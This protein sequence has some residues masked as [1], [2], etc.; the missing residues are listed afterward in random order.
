[1]KNYTT[2][3]F[4]RAH[5][6]DS[7]RKIVTVFTPDGGANVKLVQDVGRV[8]PKHLIQFTNNFNTLEALHGDD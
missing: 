3:E 4:P 7:E 1:M 2:P 8:Y 5:H 6:V